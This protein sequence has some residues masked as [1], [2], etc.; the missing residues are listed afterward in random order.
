[1]H[2]L[3]DSVHY[4]LSLYIAEGFLHVFDVLEALICLCTC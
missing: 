4:A 2:Y 1:V 3:A